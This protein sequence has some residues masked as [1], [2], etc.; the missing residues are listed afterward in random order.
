MKYHCLA[1]NHDFEAEG[2]P[3][4]P[5]CPRCMSIH[6]VESAGEGPTTATTAKRSGSSRTAAL[7]ILAL[8]GAAA[9]YY[10]LVVRDAT[11]AQDA[12]PASTE[13][14]LE[15]L[16]RLGVPAEEAV[17]PF[18]VTDRVRLLAERLAGDASGPEAL[19]KLIDGL[20]DL[21][22]AGRFTPFHQRSLR[23]D[24]PLTADE[25]AA[26]LEGD[27][28]PRALS[29]YELACLLLA[30]ARALGL[31]DARMVRIHSFAGE[32]R[33]ADPTGRFGRFGVAAGAEGKEE[34]HEA[35][36]LRTGKAAE[37]DIEPLSETAAV[38][39]FY[40]E[41]ALAALFR[42]DTPTAHRA[43]ELAVK[44]DGD[45]AA[46]RVARGLIYLAGGAPDEALAEYEK[47]LKRRPDAVNHVLL[48]DLLIK[49]GDTQATRAE[50]EVRAAIEKMPDYAQ[51]HAVLGQIYSMRQEFETAE[52]ELTL[53]EKLDPLSPEVAMA[54]AIYHMIQH[55]N[56]EAIERA[57]QAVRLSGEA[58]DALL[59]LAGIY[60]QTARFGLMREA[61][62]KV[63]TKVDSPEMARELERIFGYSPDSAVADEGDAGDDEGE[64]AAPGSGLPT[65]TPGKFELKLGGQGSPLGGQGSPLGGGGLGA[66]LQ[67]QG[68]K[69][70]GSP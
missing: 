37:G 5:R 56:S 63:L 3:K 47:A 48:A 35:F 66:P 54:W 24:P 15:Q 53:A 67:G 44:L 29:S 60:R 18:A 10:F 6:D 25:I 50:G 69:L 36:E 28:G 27:G 19:R 52:S 62:D 12:A 1:C 46:F 13:D 68:L 34:I 40:N 8:V 58:V 64:E 7:L 20:G 26:A 23:A 17:A 2:G 32:Q 31:E 38:A 70:E 41:R 42:R 57:E 9:A 16:G 39:P 55:D 49:L 21:R 61:L 59:A 4:K 33:P 14:L 11:D 51:A 45:A 65:P 43:S 30:S 22:K